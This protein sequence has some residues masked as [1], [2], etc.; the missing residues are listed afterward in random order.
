MYQVLLLT[1]VVFHILL[2]QLKL[3]LFGPELERRQQPRSVEILT[4]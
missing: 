1:P 4:H 3:W 2:H